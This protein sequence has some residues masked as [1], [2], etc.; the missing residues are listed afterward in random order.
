ML[1]NNDHM[2]NLS[3]P[4]RLLEEM[5]RCNELLKGKSDLLVESTERAD[6]AAGGELRAKSEVFGQHFYLI[7]FHR[8][9]YTSPEGYIGV[10]LQ[11]L[12][13]G[14]TKYGSC[15]VRVLHLR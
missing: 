12:Q 11:T 13:P 10:S 5:T 6:E 9:F 4:R 3:E 7:S 14:V 8:R 15:R 1:A 2:K